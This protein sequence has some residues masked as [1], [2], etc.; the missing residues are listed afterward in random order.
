MAVET[1][2]QQ[3]TEEGSS[4][5][6]RSPLTK[7]R[8]RDLAYMA[9]F[10]DGEGCIGGHCYKERPYHPY[11]YLRVCN[12]D[13]GVL[14]WIKSLFGGWIQ[15][16]ADHSAPAHWKEAFIWCAHA[17]DITPILRAL[18]PH[19]KIKQR[20]AYKAMAIRALILNK[21]EQD[22]IARGIDE[23]KLM[24]RRGR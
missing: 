13:R 7:Y 3:E 23:L 2:N 11:V 21:S 19:L 5:T 14:E 6:L 15:G 1:V 10:V 24:N 22:R 18:V 16:K 20:H 4:E 9:G 8:V 17:T 12:T